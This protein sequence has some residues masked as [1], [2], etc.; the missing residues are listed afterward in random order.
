MKLLFLVLIS[1]GTLQAE[2]IRENSVV[3]DSSTALYWQDNG[4]VNSTSLT[5]IESLNYCESLTFN[6][7]NDWHL[8]NIN[9]LM[10]IVDYTNL[11]RSIVPQAL[12]NTFRSG[13]ES[14]QWT[15]TTTADYDSNLSWTQDAWYVFFKYGYRTSDRTSS[16][17][18][19]R[20]VRGGL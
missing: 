14:E 2:Y 6:G 3:Y 1:L 16:E 8:P 5:W 13:R 12:H 19:A 20:C 4:D 17:H 7:Q 15:S 18:D 11:S 10:S 9:E